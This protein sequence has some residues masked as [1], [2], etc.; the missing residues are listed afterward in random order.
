[1]RNKI[2]NKKVFLL[3]RNKKNEKI[4]REKGKNN[5]VCLTNFK[6]KSHL[7]ILKRTQQ[8]IFICARYLKRRK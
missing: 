5:T 8:L 3:E 7:N 6:I 2:K 1:M 4:N